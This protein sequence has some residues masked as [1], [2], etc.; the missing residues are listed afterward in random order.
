MR[1]GRVLKSSD[2]TIQIIGAGLAGSECALQLA[3][4]GYNVVLYEMRPH[5]MTGAH[6]TDEA[7]ELV[8]SNSFKSER[9]DRAAGLLK[10]ELRELGSHLLQIAEQCR[11]PAGSALAVDRDRFSAQVTRALYE[12]PHISLVRKEITELPQGPTV[13]AAGPLCSTRL[14]QALDRLLGHTALFFFDAV[15]PIVD[16]ESIKREYTF[17][18][19]RY[20]ADKGDYLNCPL[21]K[22]QYRVFIRELVSAEQV[23]KHSFESHELFNACQPIEEIAKSGERSLAF[24]PLKPKGLVD[25]ANG[26]SPYA[27]V[28]LR[29]ENTYKTAY[30][31]VGF[32][33]NLTFAEQKRVFSMIPAL[34]HAEYVRYGVMHKNTFIDAPRLLTPTLQLK[35]KPVWFAGQITGTEGY[36]EAIA[37]GMLAAFNVDATLN[38]KE[39]VV[40]PKECALG[41]LIAYAT[42]SST[43]HYQ[44]MHVNFGL[45]PPLAQKLSKQERYKAYSARAKEVLYTYCNAHPW[46]LEDC[47]DR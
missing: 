44:P 7:A 41:S 30:N 37:T 29:A 16:A 12:H 20:S 10:H 14:A 43:M 3:K 13:I 46:I 6:T 27:V 18:Q 31:L 9:E 1:V 24:G 2:Q 25:P 36:T 23:K 22:E 34:K 38:A 45:M 32:Q 42:S 21:N 15:A 35:G 33:T 11:V 47:N 8:C 28:Q 5:L 17:E 4:R 26:V 40:L 39:E 19:S